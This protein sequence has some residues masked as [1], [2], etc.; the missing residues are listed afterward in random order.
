ML[1]MNLKIFIAH[2]ACCMFGILSL[3]LVLALQSIMNYTGYIIIHTIFILII[4]ATYIVAGFWANKGTCKGIIPLMYIFSLSAV[5]LTINIPVM[6]NGFNL[7]AAGIAEALVIFSNASFTRLMFI[8]MDLIW[9]FFSRLPGNI[10]F[11]IL[12][13]L[14]SSLAAIGFVLKNAY[15]KRKSI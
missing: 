5:L 2:I 7:K 10:E 8:D 4:F 11:G 14:P 1:K 13:L 9:L 12:A 15:L 6:I 3:F